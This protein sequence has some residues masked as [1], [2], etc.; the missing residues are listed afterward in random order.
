M[1]IL[2]SAVASLIASKIKQCYGRLVQGGLLIA[3]S[4]FI[5]S[6]LL[7]VT[8][9]VTLV[10]GILNVIAQT[11]TQLHWLDPSLAG[12]SSGGA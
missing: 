7:A 2:T 8:G 9:V 6:T 11:N 4:L 10:I 5:D 12:N 1:F 3:L